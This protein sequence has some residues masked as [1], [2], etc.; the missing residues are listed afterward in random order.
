MT[1]TGVLKYSDGNP[2]AEKSVRFRASSTDKNI[3]G[4]VN[5]RTDAAGRFSLKV[6]KGLS[7]EL[8]AEE[9]L[10]EGVYKNCPNVDELLAKD[11]RAS[12]QVVEAGTTR[13]IRR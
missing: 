3:D 1:L 5:A 2:V 9:W 11:G 13:P 6:L 12:I 10:V 8:S 7:G 4:D